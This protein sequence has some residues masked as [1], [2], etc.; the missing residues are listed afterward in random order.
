[1]LGRDKVKPQISETAVLP[2]VELFDIFYAT[3]FEI[4]FVSE[5]CIYRHTMSLRQFLERHYIHVVIVI[6]GDEYCID[7]WE[8]GKI[9]PR[10][11]IPLGSEPSDRAR[12]L[13]P[14]RVGENIF[15]IYLYEEG[16]MSDKGDLYSASDMLFWDKGCD[17][18][19]F[20]WVFAS[21]DDPFRKCYEFSSFSIVLAFEFERLFFAP[22]E[23]IKMFAVKVIARFAS[24]FPTCPKIIPQ[25]E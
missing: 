19:F 16:R 12:S 5:S 11:H 23:V 20:P 14:Y 24:I 22:P 21:F 2:P 10:I 17:R 4:L 15:A 18:S 7:M 8:F 3:L 9:N 6:V 1:M 25:K 13:R